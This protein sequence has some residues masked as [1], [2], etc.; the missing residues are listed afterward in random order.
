MII[1]II[2]MTATTTVTFPKVKLGNIRI[3]CLQCHCLDNVKERI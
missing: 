1:I 2:I 3:V